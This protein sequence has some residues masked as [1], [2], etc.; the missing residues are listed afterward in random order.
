MIAWIPMVITVM[1]SAVTPSRYL[2]LHRY[3]E[4]L[5]EMVGSWTPFLSLA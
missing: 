1:A 5:T 4:K 3:S 2:S